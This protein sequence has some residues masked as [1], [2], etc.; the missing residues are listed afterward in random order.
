[1]SNNLKYGVSGHY[2]GHKGEEYFFKVKQGAYGT[3]HGQIEAHKFCHFIRP[4]DIVLDFGCGSGGLL[5]ALE[6]YRRIGVEINPIALQRSKEVGNECYTDLCEVPNR[7]ADVVISN[8]V[9]EHVPYPI[10]ALRQIKSKIKPGGILVLCVPIDDWRVHKNYQPDN[11]NHHLHTWTIQ[12]LGNTLSEAGFA[13]HDGDISVLTH[14]WPRY[15]QFLY[16]RLPL[17]LFNFLCTVWAIFM[18]KRQLFAKVRL[19]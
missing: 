14:A 15:Y 4:S 6:C 10:E 1:M 2:L 12:L 16:K 19:M 13:V 18:K 8:H 9:L 3:L 7:I 17:P 11:P 5:Q